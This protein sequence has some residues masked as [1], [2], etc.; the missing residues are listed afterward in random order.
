[1]YCP[2]CD[3]EVNSSVRIIPETYPVKGEDITIEAHVRFCDRCGT[4]M[5]DEKL[6]AKNL[7]DAFAEYRK[8]HSL[9]QPEDIR[10]T[11]EKYGLSQTAFARVL[12]MGD[13]TITRYEN[14]SIPDA[15]Q[16]NLI[17][18]V[19][20]PSDF[21]RLL[22]QSKDKISKADYETAL[23]ALERLRCRF[24]YT[25]NKKTYTYS[26]NEGIRYCVPQMYWGDRNYA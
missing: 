23:A 21:L 14:G 19:E 1:M 12:G 24:V 20:Q 8:R 16:N 25:D 17:M 18:L 4:D 6:D 13:K 10:A 5:W 3:S 9:L 2:N 15:A 22:E 7:L 26:E 11:R